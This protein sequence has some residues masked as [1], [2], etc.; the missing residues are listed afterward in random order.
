MDK[1]EVKRHFQINKILGNTKQRHI[2]TKMEHML[3]TRLQG[4][5]I[6]G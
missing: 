6:S 2:I 1:L 3:D 4:V 5:F